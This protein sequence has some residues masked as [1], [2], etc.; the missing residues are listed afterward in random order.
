MQVAILQVADIASGKK[1]R[2]L[3]KIIRD[4][5]DAKR[6]IDIS[7]HEHDVLLSARIRLNQLNG[8]RESI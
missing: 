2:E 4:L 7:E 5:D 6:T 8:K 1:D 3:R